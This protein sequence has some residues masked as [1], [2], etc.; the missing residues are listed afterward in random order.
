MYQ[1]RI[2]V[3][4]NV[5]QYRIIAILLVIVVCGVAIFTAGVLLV[6][7]LARAQGYAQPGQGLLSIFPPILVN[8]IVIMLLLIIVGIF[9]T[10]RMAGPIFRVQAD[11]DKVLSGEKNVRV[12]FRRH[13]AFPELAEKVNKLIE[14]IDNQ[15]RR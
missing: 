15:P 7:A 9:L 13:D 3:I 1:R 14:R 4:D 6:S 2:K 10:H 11:I 5:F 8:D 12:K